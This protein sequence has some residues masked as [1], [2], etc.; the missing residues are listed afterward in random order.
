MAAVTIV[1]WTQICKTEKTKR[2]V[3]QGLATLKP[4]F[5]IQSSTCCFGT[6]CTEMQPVVSYRRVS[7]QSHLGSHQCH[8]KVFLQA[9]RW[10]SRWH[11]YDERAYTPAPHSSLRQS[12]PHSHCLH[13]TSRLCWYNVLQIQDRI[14]FE[15]KCLTWHYVL[16]ILLNFKVSWSPHQS[17]CSQTW[18]LGR[19]CAWHPHS[20]SHHS[21]PCSQY[22]HHS[23]NARGCTGHPS[24]TETHLYDNLQADEWLR[25][26]ETIYDSK[27]TSFSIVSCIN[28]IRT[29]SLE[30]RQC[31]ASKDG[32]NNN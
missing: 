32:E 25:K 15:V 27:L 6:P 30:R 13:H 11:T 20:S 18:L 9:G 8:H 12:C 14:N 16:Y 4:C 23:A 5:E 1:Q 22:P 26:R 2:W 31:A 24:D 3:T 19:T 29:H 17:P 10:W 21:G 7:H 28:Q